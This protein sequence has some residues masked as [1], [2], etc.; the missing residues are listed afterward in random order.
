MGNLDSK[1]SRNVI[2][3]IQQ[4]SE[5]Y[6]QTVVIGTHSEE[7]AKRAGQIIRMED[8]NFYTDER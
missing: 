3:L 2:E 8:G 1:A 5:T 6:N 7:I 4:M